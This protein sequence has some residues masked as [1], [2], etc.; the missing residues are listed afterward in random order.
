MKRQKKKRV[1]RA[2]ECSP[3][4]ITKSSSSSLDEKLDG[5][6]LV[7]IATRF[8]N[9]VCTARGSQYVLQASGEHAPAEDRSI[10]WMPGSVCARS[11]AHQHALALSQTE[12]INLDAIGWQEKTMK[13]HGGGTANTAHDNLSMSCSLQPRD[14]ESSSAETNTQDF[15]HKST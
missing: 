14:R 7:A 6:R 13:A 3:G 15:S 8:Q 10:E 2:Q 11:R 5:R 4:T 12:V 1:T 9:A